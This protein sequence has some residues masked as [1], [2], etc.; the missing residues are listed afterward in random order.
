MVQNN[1]CQLVEKSGFKPWFS[2]TQT[3]FFS[4]TALLLFLKLRAP[5]LGI[6]IPYVISLIRP[7]FI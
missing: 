2:D 6:C 5:V 3:M 4:S 1:L 7:W